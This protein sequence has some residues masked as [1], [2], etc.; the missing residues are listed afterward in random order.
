M[1]SYKQGK[2]P[3]LTPCPALLLLTLTLTFSLLAAEVLAN[4]ACLRVADFLA[5]DP[6]G[7]REVDAF[8]I[9]VP[10]MDFAIIV[11]P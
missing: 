9:A 5:V 6:D 2:V 4:L 10:R 8:I 11:N 1:Q 3:S 7:L